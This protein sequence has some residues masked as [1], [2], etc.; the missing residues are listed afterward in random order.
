MTNPDA[1]HPPRKDQPEPSEPHPSGENN[2][3]TAR[4]LR[5]ALH[6]GFETQR[7]FVQMARRT[8][9]ITA[10]APYST[11]PSF[12]AAMAIAVGI[13]YFVHNCRA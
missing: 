6:A 4:A 7:E 10:C 11:K 9:D 2:L 12:L 5:D 1:I 8:N 13:S 3:I